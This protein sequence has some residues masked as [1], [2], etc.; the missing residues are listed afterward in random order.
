VGW[1]AG[2]NSKSSSN[3]SVP[4]RVEIQQSTIN[5]RGGRGRGAIAMEAERAVI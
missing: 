5:R 1:G 4:A 3:T 2:G